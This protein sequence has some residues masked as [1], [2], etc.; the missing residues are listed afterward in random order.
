MGVYVC[1]YVCLHQIMYANAAGKI[2]LNE[3]LLFFGR[4]VKGL[5]SKSKSIRSHEGCCFS[6]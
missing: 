6:Y 2:Q 1:L 5:M 4:K 3:I